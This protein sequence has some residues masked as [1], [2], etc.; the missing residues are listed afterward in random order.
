MVPEEKRDTKFYIDN[1]QDTVCACGGPKSAFLSF[2]PD[3]FF[4]LPEELR[5]GLQGPLNDEDYQWTWNKSYEFL[6]EEGTII[7]Y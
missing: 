2:C 4:S 3:C 7:E 6:K 5:E 1:Y